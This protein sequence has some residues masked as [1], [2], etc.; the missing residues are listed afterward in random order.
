MKE[1]KCVR[2]FLFKQMIK[3][4]NKNYKYVMCYVCIAMCMKR[5]D[6]NT[7]AVNINSF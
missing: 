5:H 3:M 6:I 1:T 2:S 7:L 4:Q